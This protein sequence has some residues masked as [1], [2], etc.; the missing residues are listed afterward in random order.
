[1]SQPNP[2][3]TNKPISAQKAAAGKSRRNRA[4]QKRLEHCQGSILLIGQELGY[5]EKARYH[6]EQVDPNPKKVER[7]RASGHFEGE[8]GRIVLGE[9]GA[10]GQPSQNLNI[11]DATWK[12]RHG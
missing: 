5:D 11:G 9:N 6:K 1:M 3:D 4:S 12:S 8:P 10:D 2:S 7:Q